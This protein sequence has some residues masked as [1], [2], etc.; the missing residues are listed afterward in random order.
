MRL[1][2]D[3]HVHTVYSDGE[4]TVD[5]VLATAEQRGL[6]GIAITDH[7]TITGALE[8]RA[9]SKK[10]IVVPGGELTTDS[11][12]LVALGIQTPL[13]AKLGYTEA[14][15]EIR[16]LNGVAVLVHPY[17]GRPKTAVWKA[18]KPDAVE[19]INSLYPFFTY[20]T[21]KSRILAESLNLPKLGG[22]D[23]HYASNVGDAYSIIEADDPTEDDALESIRRN[24]TTPEGG[25]SPTTRRL[26][27]GLRYILSS[28]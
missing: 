3:L 23:A 4:G 1:K 16:R 28:I 22:S 19:T 21:R 20:L 12:H 26:R 14:L 13:P 8:A 2:L 15:K 5:E 10:L 18:H 27:L 6:D 11:G 17:A 9:K 25:P 7:E 24:L